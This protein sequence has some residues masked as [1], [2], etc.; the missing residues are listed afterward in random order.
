MNATD[1]G[2]VDPTRIVSDFLLV[3][4]AEDEHHITAA[5]SADPFTR[6]RLLDECTTKRRLIDAIV[7]ADDYRHHHPI[8]FA[9]S[10]NVANHEFG[11]L[12]NLTY[13]YR[14]RKD[15][16]VAWKDDTK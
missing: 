16:P 8:T 5:P 1:P 6:K 11:V 9:G 15:C 2:Y 3:R 10:A 14:R 13:P 7:T 12:V 4:I